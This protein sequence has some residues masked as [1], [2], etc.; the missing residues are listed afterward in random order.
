MRIRNLEL[1]NRRWQR[2]RFRSHPKGESV[3]SLLATVLHRT[4]GVRVTRL[5]ERPPARGGGDVVV[6]SITRQDCYGGSCKRL[7][8]VGLSLGIFGEVTVSD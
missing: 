3:K 5:W 4:P 1:G 7:F 2:L 6:N 8:N